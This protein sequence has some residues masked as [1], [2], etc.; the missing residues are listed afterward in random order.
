MQAIARI[1]KTVRGGEDLQS[2][3]LKAATAIEPDEDVRDRMKKIR[4]GQPLGG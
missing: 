1:L 2:K 4:D 3:T